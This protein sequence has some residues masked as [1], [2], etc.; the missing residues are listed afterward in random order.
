MPD[1]SCSLSQEDAAIT[2]TGREVGSKYLAL[3]S[4]LPR[5][6]PLTNQ[7]GEQRVREC[8]DSGHKC[9]LPGKQVEEGWRVDLRGQMHKLQHSCLLTSSARMP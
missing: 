6:D 2:I 3:L 5:P 8:I 4:L 7:V 9:W 1:R